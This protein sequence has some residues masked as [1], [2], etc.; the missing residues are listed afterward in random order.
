[1]Y[2]PYPSERGGKTWKVTGWTSCLS[3]SSGPICPISAICGC[4]FGQDPTAWCCL[5]VRGAALSVV[6]WLT[7]VSCDI[8]FFVVV[9]FNLALAKPSRGV[10]QKQDV[11]QETLSLT[12]L[13][14]SFHVK[15]LGIWFKQ[16][17][18]RCCSI[19]A[20][21]C[22]CSCTLSISGAFFNS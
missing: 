7:T 6:P 15:T 2:L 19:Y 1:M 8:L 17:N 20:N 11:H 13:C 4:K 5:L 18:S 10:K 9:F 14:S 16:Q 3:H 21:L 12:I 22:S